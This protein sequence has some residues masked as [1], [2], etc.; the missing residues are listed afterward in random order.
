MIARGSAAADPV[1][2]LLSR[3][4]PHI[5]AA[6]ACWDLATESKQQH[7][8]DNRLPVELPH[9]RERLPARAEADTPVARVPE[10]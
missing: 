1:R 10:Q 3:D 4:L 8:T 2:R 9:P 6:R 5:A 7:R